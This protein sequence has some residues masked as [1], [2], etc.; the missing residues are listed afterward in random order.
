[1]GAE[2]GGAL[3][4]IYRHPI[5]SLG[6]EALDRVTLT[7]GQPLPWDRTWALAHDRSAFNAVEPEWVGSRNFVI[8]STN[9]ALAQV[10]C[11]LDDVAEAVTLSHPILGEITVRPDDEGD[12]LGA[13]LA[14]IAGAS[15]PGPYRIARLAAGALHDFPDTH[16]SIGN[17][18]SL[19]ALEEMAGRSL[20]HIR[21]RMNLWVDGFAPW[22]ELEWSSLHIGPAKLT[23]IDRCK[24]CSAT[25]ADPSTGTRTTDLTR[26]LHG[27]FGH[28]DFGVYAQVAEG[29]EVALGQEA[30]P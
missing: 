2:R 29:G 26:L 5:K 27:R 13:W 19:R 30:R 9:P 11:R 10:G 16:V 1:M 18:A 28:M 21:F 6:D 25:N 24:R 20:E 7:P 22:E 12:A 15:G 3:A 23:V 8:Q 14:P 4:A 17:L